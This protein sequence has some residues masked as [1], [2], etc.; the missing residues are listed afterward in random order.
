M[1]YQ[2]QIATFWEQLQGTIELLLSSRTDDRFDA[3]TLLKE[4][5]DQLKEIDDNLTFH[6]EHDEDVDDRVDMIFGCDGF[7]ES[8]PSVLSLIGAAPE[9]SGIRF[10]AFNHRYDPVPQQINMGDEE[11]LL[12]DFWCR[13]VEIGDSLHLEIYLEDAPVVLDMDPR[14][15]AVMIFL[16]ALIGEYEL[17]TRITAL[18]WFDLPPEP[19]DYGLTPLRRLR[20]EFDAKKHQAKPLG[21]VLH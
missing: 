16:D 13:L 17:M 7:P 6:F 11:C 15:E 2:K 20:R 4:Y 8:I 12:K 10:K 5:R 19:E 14:V 1:N 18:D 3:E 21:I 9:L